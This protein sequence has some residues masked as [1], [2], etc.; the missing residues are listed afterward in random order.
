MCNADV[1]PLTW[2]WDEERR[3]TTAKA[4]V[5]HSCRRFDKIQEWAERYNYPKLMDRSHRAVDD[6]LDPET[7]VDGFS[8]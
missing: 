7:W 5:V 1:T 2:L 4:T 8:A 3:Q 6:P